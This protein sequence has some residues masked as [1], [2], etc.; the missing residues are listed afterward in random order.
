MD[1]VL[2]PSTLNLTTQLVQLTGAGEFAEREVLE[3]DTVW[4]YTIPPLNRDEFYYKGTL[5]DLTPPVIENLDYQS[6]NQS[7]CFVRQLPGRAYNNPAFEIDFEARDPNSVLNFTYF[8]GSYENGDDLISTTEI[9][10]KR[11]I[12]P[13]NLLPA[14]DIFFRVIARNLN[15][16]ESIASC[17]L[18]NEAYYDRSPP[19]ARINPIQ[20]VSSHQSQIR[21]LIVLFDEHGLDGSQEIAIGVVPGENG[22]DVMPWTRFN[23]SQ[24]TTPP[25]E[26]GDV[27]NLFSF[28]RVC[29]CVFMIVD[30]V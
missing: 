1:I 27:M 4:E 14:R 30:F 8:V 10:G 15:G 9:G 26:M 5:Q 17:S 19:L 21:A 7:G 22:D 25:N 20:S 6:P 11:I 28:G 12:V 29:V 3:R 24:I 2:V 23:T 16:L 18:P 13:H